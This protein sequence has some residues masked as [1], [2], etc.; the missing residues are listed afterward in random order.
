MTND[1]DHH[2]E[3]LCRCRGMKRVPIQLVKISEKLLV[4][5]KDEELLEM[6]E[7]AFVV[8]G[9]QSCGGLFR[10]HHTRLR[11]A[12]SANIDKYRLTAHNCKVASTESLSLRNRG[13]LC[14][15]DIN[16]GGL[17]E[18]YS[19]ELSCDRKIFKIIY[20]FRCPANRK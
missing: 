17:R 13:L 16:T 20:I 15:K 6:I 12:V 8:K 5:R 18:S 4:G 19:C 9:L 2:H 14:Q 7:W 11:C 10:F 3:E 1:W